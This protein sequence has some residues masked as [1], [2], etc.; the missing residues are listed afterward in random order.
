MTLITQN[1]KRRHLQRQT[2]TN[3]MKARNDIGIGIAY[4]S[5]SP[6]SFALLEGC[7]LRALCITQKNFNGRNNCEDRQFHSIPIIFTTNNNNE[8]K[9]KTSI[10]D[11]PTSSGNSSSLGS[12]HYLECL[13]WDRNSFITSTAGG[14]FNN[15]S[16]FSSDTCTNTEQLFELSVG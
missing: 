7:A 13:Q 6:A 9:N 1:A 3:S 4:C 15:C 5:A 2:A 16:R 10:L 8:T 11:S 12:Q 14:Y